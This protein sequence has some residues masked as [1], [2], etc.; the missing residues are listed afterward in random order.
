[1]AK[2]KKSFDYGDP[3]PSRFRN[4]IEKKRAT[5]DALAAEFNTTRQT[6]SNWQNG[7]TVPDAVSI[8]DIARYFGVTTD[9]LLG[10]TDVKTIETNVRAVAEYTGLSEDAVK[11]LHFP[12]YQEDAFLHNMGHNVYIIDE[13]SPR[14]DDNETWMISQLIEDGAL[15]TIASYLG[16]IWDSTVER[17]KSILQ[18]KRKIENE[19]FND[20]FYE[21]LFYYHNQSMSYEEFSKDSLELSKFKKS[22][23]GLSLDELAHIRLMF[24]NPGEITV[25]EIDQFRIQKIIQEFIARQMKLAEGFAT[26]QDEING[27]TN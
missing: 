15:Y 19:R 9:Y 21:E 22:I 16:E 5:L 17:T 6:V 8:C 14:I 27:K 3:F 25:T 4:L 11:E 18:E 26:E 7:V 1:M 23:D 2:T 12:Y 20:E 10:L 13:D 24:G